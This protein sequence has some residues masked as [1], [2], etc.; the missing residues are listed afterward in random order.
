M[1]L[2]TITPDLPQAWY[3]KLSGQPCFR[4]A[5]A[6]TVARYGEVTAWW[7]DGE[8]ISYRTLHEWAIAL[9]TSSSPVWIDGNHTDWLAQALACWL[10][11]KA[12]L[13][14]DGTC[15]RPA[16]SPRQAA[17]L[18][19]GTHAIYFT[20][21]TTGEPKPVVRSTT[22]ALR[23]AW[24]YA[25]D[26]SLPSGRTAVALV[27]PWFGALTKHSLGM[28]LS[29]T[30]QAFAKSSNLADSDASVLYCTPSQAQRI[31]AVQRWDVISLTGEPVSNQHRKGLSDM[32]APNG[33]ILDALGSTECGVIARR[34]INPDS[35]SRE[36]GNFV[37]EV[38]PGK[39]VSVD[40]DKRLTVTLF[41]GT[42]LFTGDLAVLR[43][44]KIEL[45]GRASAL[46]KAHGVW[47]DSTPLLRALRVHPDIM[48][49]ELAPEATDQQQLVVR[50][51]CP[52]TLTLTTLESWLLEALSDLWLFPVI[53]RFG[54]D[55]V[56]GPTGK[57]QLCGPASDVTQPR[58]LAELVADIV[59]GEIALP[60]DAKVTNLRFDALGVDS[61]DFV[62]VAMELEARTGVD[63]SETLLLSDTP[64]T[65]R[66]RLGNPSTNPFGFHQLANG[67]GTRELLCLGRSL[68][69]TQSELD[70]MIS[71]QL[72]PCL[73]TQSS[74]YT[75]AHLARQLLVN[76]P[77][78]QQVN[79]P[80]LVVGFS[81]DA[82]L[83]IELAFALET[84]GIPVSGVL[85][86]DPPT[87]KRRSW[88]RKR[89]PLLG[90]WLT[91]RW[92]RNRTSFSRE[93]RRRAIARQP[94]RRLQA[95]V[96]VLHRGAAECC[97]LDEQTAIHYVGL[98]DVPHK[99]LIEN[100]TARA[101]WLVYFRQWSEEHDL[102]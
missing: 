17:S 1:T 49:A 24:A 21:G 25:Q 92:F 76:N 33:W 68:A 64:R 85:L 20:S 93:L 60:D 7:R 55:T 77:S 41:E 50:I 36:L 47:Y 54:E 57:R 23:E 22:F 79:R 66:R 13:F 81:L 86:L 9:Q 40:E 43:D 10:E 91:M 18:P 71:F 2:L 16:L 45:L 98:E 52:K 84:S 97:W 19:T 96:T 67:S 59:L 69:S 102:R 74:R 38:L 44:R 75:L 15:S 4:A 32:L 28:L 100:P 56:L 37:G 42:P 62:S 39:L 90:E 11:G 63:V 95:P 27:R 80:R 78:L 83:A 34:W 72:S 101:H 53:E 35:L 51:A 26:L 99:A 29:G 14:Y 5:W 65:V 3:D 61:L 89:T 70:P 8:P 31:G 87:R 46:R 73:R 48:H 94:T 58:S 6:A 30:A 82:V 88:L 12:V